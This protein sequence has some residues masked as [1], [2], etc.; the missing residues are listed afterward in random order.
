MFQGVK[1]SSHDELLIACYTPRGIYI[2]RHDRKLGV[3]LNG[4]DTTVRGVNI[5]ISGTR[6]EFDWSVALDA[7]LLKLHASDCE[8]V[9]MVPWD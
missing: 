4:K 7:I 8:Y 9:A 1:F 6:S 5:K 3:S 2:F